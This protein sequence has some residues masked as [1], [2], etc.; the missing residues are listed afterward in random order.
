M[1]YAISC[2]CK[3]VFLPLKYLLKVFYGIKNRI[4]YNNSII[5]SSSYYSMSKSIK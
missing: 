4:N 1:K 2:T 5:N 3:I